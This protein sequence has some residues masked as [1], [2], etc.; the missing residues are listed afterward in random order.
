M[1][2]LWMVEGK[3]PGTGSSTAQCPYYTRGVEPLKRK[4]EYYI[5]AFIG[6]YLKNILKGRGQTLGIKWDMY[7]SYL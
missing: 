7:R 6:I 3:E 4:K 5:Y 1:A 2:A